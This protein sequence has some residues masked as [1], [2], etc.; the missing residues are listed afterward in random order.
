MINL[1][2]TQ[3]QVL[4]LESYQMSRFLKWWQ[5]NQ[6]RNKLKNKVGLKYTPKIKLLIS[7]SILVLVFEILYLKPLTFLLSVL[8]IHLSFPFTLLGISLVIIKPYETVR[9]K[10]TIS[11]T[12]KTILS[13]RKLTTIGITGSYG[14]TT[15]KN[16]LLSI[17]SKHQETVSTPESYNTTFGVAKCVALEICNKSRYFI[18]EM[19]AYHQGEIKELCF[20]APPKFALLIS[21]GPQHLERLG[22]LDNATSANFELIDSVDPKNA[23]VNIDNPLIAEKLKGFRYKS[24]KTFSLNSKSSAD[25]FLTDFKMNR[26]GTT[27]TI[28]SSIDQ[29][30]HQFTAPVFGSSNLVNLT[31]AI[32]MALLLKIPTEHITQG[33][34]SVTPSPHRLQLIRLG[35]ATIIDDS[36]SSNVEGFE[37]IIKDLSLQKGKKVIITPGVVELGPLTKD[38]HLN[39]GNKIGSVFDHAFLVGTSDRTKYIQQGIGK[40]FKSTFLENNINVW[41]LCQELSQKYD[42]ILIE[43]DLPENY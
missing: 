38:F 3:L 12:R 35:G 13:S 26:H 6:F 10:L 7:V 39:I 29:S 43:N 25:F 40:K 8:V 15:T 1:F 22:S 36:Y 4:Q 27:L 42:W 28:H 18:C 31:A 20:Q 5:H 17:L 30:N 23:L 34:K 2:I 37:N 41:N 33:L 21:V 9:K 16:Y 24:V 19:D 32:S 11:H 14:K